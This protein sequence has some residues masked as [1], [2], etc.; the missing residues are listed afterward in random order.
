MTIYEIDNEILSCV[1]METGEIIDEEKLSALEI[2][3]DVKISNIACWIKDL[4]AEVDAIKVERQ[5]L[6]R[7][8]EVASN[9]MESLKNYLSFALNGEK[10]K[11][12]RCSIS[13]RTSNSVSVPEDISG[14]DERFKRI[15][16]DANKTAIKE[17]IE[18]GEEVAG[19]SIEQKISMIIK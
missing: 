14:L 8:S 13:Y 7:R 16:V 12:G 5:N 17:A 1:D 9:K 18:N 10:F 3:R 4:K 6:A 11:D 19:C 15:S 2:E